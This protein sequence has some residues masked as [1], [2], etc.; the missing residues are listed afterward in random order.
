M[1]RKLQTAIAA[2]DLGNLTSAEIVWPSVRVVFDLWL[3][4]RDMS[5]TAALRPCVKGLRSI[6]QHLM[7]CFLLFLQGRMG[8]VGTHF[9]DNFLMLV[10]E[11]CVSV[12]GM[13]D[14]SPMQDCRNNPDDDAFMGD[15]QPF[16]RTQG[17][18]LFVNVAQILW[19]PI[20][21]RFRA[22]LTSRILGG[23]EF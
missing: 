15:S 5:A 20:V 14:T 3:Y 22:R 12:G 23:L 13:V 11:K 18:A 17:S 9:I 7:R 6:L 16:V 1:Q 2:G 21:Q 4:A 19:S 8:V 10:G